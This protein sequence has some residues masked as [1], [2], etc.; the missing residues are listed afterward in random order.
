MK[1]RFSKFGKF[2]AGEKWLLL[3]CFIL[4]I[5][6]WQGIRHNTSFEVTVS[7]VPVEIVVPD[8]WALLEKSASSVSI[9]FRGAREE[10]RYLNSGHQLRIEIPISDPVAGK[11]VH[12]PLVEK[13]L[14]N[15]TDAKPV[16]FTPPEILVRLDRKSERLLPVKAKVSGTLPEGIEVDRIVCTPAAVRVSGAEQVL[17]KMQHVSTEAVSLD[18]RQIS[19]KESTQIALPPNGRIKVD[20]SWVYVDFTLVQHA[21]TQDFDNIPVRVLLAPGETR[22]VSLSPEA[23]RITLSGPADRMEQVRKN[24]IFAYVNCAELIENATYDLPLELHLPP[25]L[26]FVK[27]V[28]SVVHV[29]IEN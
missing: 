23:V 19:F 5:L 27:A 14:Q 1:N 25:G 6:S 24:E 12:I 3:L 28:P 8:G 21:N 7:N 26:K 29:D 18:N 22:T 10:I 11:E 17:D 9:L 20:P 16:R 4:G 2:L 15:P 13:Y